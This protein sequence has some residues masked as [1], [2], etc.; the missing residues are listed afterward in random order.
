MV[1]LRKICQGL[2]GVFAIIG[3]AQATAYIPSQLK[4]SGRPLIIPVPLYDK[5]SGA[6]LHRNTTALASRPTFG[7][8]RF[9]EDG[10]MAYF[11]KH[12]PLIPDSFIYSIQDSEGYSVKVKVLIDPNR[13]PIIVSHG[14]FR[15]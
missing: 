9:L 14:R 4:V 12:R 15:W 10:S 7:R 8:V 2:I 3:A 11:P 13:Y 1:M 6:L 5:E